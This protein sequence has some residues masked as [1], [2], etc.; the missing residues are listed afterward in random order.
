M[1]SFI[2]GAEDAGMLFD[3]RFTAVELLSDD[4][5]KAAVFRIVR[6]EAFRVTSVESH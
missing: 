5:G 3:E 1:A 2:D 6:S 4:V